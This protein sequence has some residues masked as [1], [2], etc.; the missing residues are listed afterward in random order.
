MLNNIEGKSKLSCTW[1]DVAFVVYALL[2]LVSIFH[3]I[4]TASAIYESTKVLLLLFSYWAWKFLI[5]KLKSKEQFYSSLALAACIASFLAI[6]FS[7]ESLFDALRSRDPFSSTVYFVEGLHGHK[8]LLSAWIL[9]LIP[10]N[11]L[12]FYYPIKWPRLLHVLTFLFQVSFITVLQGRASIL[13]LVVGSMAFLFL[14][15][16]ARSKSETKNKILKYAKV[17]GSLVGIFAAVILVLAFFEKLPS[18]LFN[19][20]Q[21]SGSAKERLLIWQSTISLIKQHPFMGVGLGNWCIYLPSIGLEGLYRATEGIIVFVRPHNDYLW[22]WAELGTIGFASFIALFF[23]HLSLG[24]KKLI[25]NPSNKSNILAI[26]GLLAYLIV[27]FF[28]FPKERAE[29]QIA[30]LFLFLLLLV[31]TEKLY[32]KKIVEVELKLLKAIGLSFSLII[33]FIFLS[34]FGS[35]KAM[36]QAIVFKDSGQSLK[37]KEACTQ[38]LTYFYTSENNGVPIVW[39]RGIANY[40]LG[41]KKASHEDFL[42]SKELNPYNFNVLNNLGTIY[43]EQKNYPLAIENYEAAL[44]INP[45]FEDGL[46]NLTAVYVNTNQ[47]E[48]ALPY[49]NRCQIQSSRSNNLRQIINN[50]L[51]Q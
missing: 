42:L 51:S 32:S 2:S 17:A 25:A 4:S 26:S 46:L 31:D 37:S 10:L 23:G 48:K 3:A 35:E 33:G 24:V 8:N 5:N 18:N 27:S 12:G 21:F 16:F 43:F 11:A 13:G 47:F 6:A 19:P 29:H 36:K 30:L 9:L 44:K 28:D 20:N 41:D 1:L 7:M 14:N 45:I 50:N 40:H 38:A 15:F 39:Y 49:L 34:R 22:V